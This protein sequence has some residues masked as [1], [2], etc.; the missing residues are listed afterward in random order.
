MK[1]HIFAFSRALHDACRA[2]ISG[3]DSDIRIVDVGAFHDSW[4]PWGV[5]DVFG[6]LFYLS[7]S[8]SSRLF[9]RFDSASVHHATIMM[10]T[11]A[12]VIGRRGSYSFF[13]LPPV[14]PFAGL[15]GRHSVADGTTGAVRSRVPSV[16]ASHLQAPRPPGSVVAHGHVPVRVGSRA[17]AGGHVAAPAAAHARAAALVDLA[18]LA[19]EVRGVDA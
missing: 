1:K 8:L 11:A 4:C 7:V 19:H 2:L 17:Q 5:C 6:P 16:G 15:L 12:S 9:R 14:T 10:T 3:V 18:R 13:F